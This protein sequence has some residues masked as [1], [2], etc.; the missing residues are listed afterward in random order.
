M[1]A[2]R[3]VHRLEASS[4]ACVPSPEGPHAPATRATRAHSPRSC[5]ELL[6][7][8]D[9]GQRRHVSDYLAGYRAYAGR[10]LLAK[11]AAIEL[12]AERVHKLVRAEVGYRVDTSGLLAGDRWPIRAPTAS[13][14]A[15]AVASPSWASSRAAQ[16]QLW[17]DDRSDIFKL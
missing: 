12:L 15:A 4:I 13:C 3:A 17:R 16:R 6:A 2:W 1:P 11:G 14:L 8:A 5:N 10:R 7:L 9:A